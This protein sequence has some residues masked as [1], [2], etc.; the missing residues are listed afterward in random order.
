MVNIYSLL[1][2]LTENFRII[3]GWCFD[4]VCDQK[5]SYAEFQRDMFCY[6]YIHLNVKILR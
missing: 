3:D 4:D 6:V 2:V 1:Q 5:H